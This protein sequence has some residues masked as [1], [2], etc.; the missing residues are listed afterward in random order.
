MYYFKSL[1]IQWI[2]QFPFTSQDNSR[3][4][5]VE[6]SILKLWTLV[7]ASSMIRLLHRFSIYFLLDLFKGAISGAS[8]PMMVDMIF[9]VTR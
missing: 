6:T 7:L 8:G 3:G 1:D 2:F 4:H 9:P 5:M